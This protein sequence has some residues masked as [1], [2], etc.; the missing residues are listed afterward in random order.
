MRRVKK[1]FHIENINH[2]TGMAYNRIVR[3][4]SVEN[5][6]RYVL[7]HMAPGTYMI[8]ELDPT[9]MHPKP[10]RSTAAYKHAK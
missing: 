6:I 1:V 2:P 5:V 4:V 7:P 8:H 10:V 9:T 3:Y